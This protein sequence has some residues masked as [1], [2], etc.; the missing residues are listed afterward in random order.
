MKK[1]LFQFIT[2]TSLAL[3]LCLTFSCQKQGEEV[4]EEA[5]PAVDVEADIT[6]INEIWTQYV[7]TLIAGD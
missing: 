5:K 3:L 2:I 4:A 6:A 7:A 1:S